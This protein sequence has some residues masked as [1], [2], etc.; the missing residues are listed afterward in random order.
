MDARSFN[1]GAVGWPFE[2]NIASNARY[3]TS[4][5]DIARYSNARP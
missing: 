5:N 1:S 4:D 2:W 3:R